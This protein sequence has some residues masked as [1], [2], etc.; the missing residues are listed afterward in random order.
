MTIRLQSMKRSLHT[1]S[2]ANLLYLNTRWS[3]IDTALILNP[4]VQHP[5]LL[6]MTRKKKPARKTS[7]GKSQK[8]RPRRENL[9]LF[10]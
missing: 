3:M 1:E 2:T 6:L 4:K 8:V 5:A 9:R 7:I 10:E